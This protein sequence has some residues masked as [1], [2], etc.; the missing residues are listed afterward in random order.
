MEAFIGSG[1]KTSLMGQHFYNDGMNVKINVWPW[2][3]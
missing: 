1:K 2:L 3:S